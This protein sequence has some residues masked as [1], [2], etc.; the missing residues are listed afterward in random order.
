MFRCLDCGNSQDSE[1]VCAVCGSEFT[2]PFVPCGIRMICLKCQPTVR[3]IVDEDNDPSCPVCEED[4]IPAP[5]V[6]RE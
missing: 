4:G 2:V 3:W 6:G 1:G 5:E